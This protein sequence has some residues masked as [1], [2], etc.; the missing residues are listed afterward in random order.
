[1]LDGWVKRLVAWDRTHEA[2][3]RAE[4][5]DE[6]AVLRW[7]L[8]EI[9]GSMWKYKDEHGRG[10]LLCIRWA[11]EHHGTDLRTLL[12]GLLGDSAGQQ[13]DATGD[14]LRTRVLALEKQN[15]R[16]TEQVRRLEGYFGQL[17]LIPL[18]DD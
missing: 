14:A 2:M 13:V 4:T 11:I 5:A 3:K 7:R 17:E 6:R 12:W 16:L 8:D 15:E 18:A 9:S 1:M 10:L